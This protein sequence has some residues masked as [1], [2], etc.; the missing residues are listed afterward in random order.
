MWL[1]IWTLC[2]RIS[3]KGAINVSVRAEVS[4]EVPTGEIFVSELIQLLIKISFLRNIE[5]RAS[6]FIHCCPEAALNFLS[7]GECLQF[8]SS[9]PGRER[10]SKQSL[11]TRWKLSSYIQN[12][13]LCHI[14]SLKQVTWSCSHSGGEDYT[15]TFIPGDQEVDII[16]NHSRSHLL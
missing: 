2:C 16:S 13:H 4:S 5:W 10:G 1:L 12:H 11:L 14:L 15:W 8:A 6:T 7:L 3:R 9:K